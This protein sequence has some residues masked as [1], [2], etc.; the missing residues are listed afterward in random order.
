MSRNS[1]VVVTKTQLGTVA[2]QDMEFG[3][4]MLEKFFHVLESQPEKP[5]VICFYTEGVK[6]ICNESPCL[7]S[8]QLLEGMGVRLIACQTCLEY[9]DISDQVAVGEVVGMPHIL[10]TLME[11]EN[12]ITI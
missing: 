8:L 12:V 4:E 10:N 6:V 1:A 2:D 7:M 9:Y 3:S 5:E 11:A